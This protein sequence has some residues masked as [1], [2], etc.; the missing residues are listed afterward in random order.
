MLAGDLI[1]SWMPLKLGGIK[2]C[3]M[4][5]H[6]PVYFSADCLKLGGVLVRLQLRAVGAP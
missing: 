4:G 1:Q 2:R 5:I 3:P 6:E